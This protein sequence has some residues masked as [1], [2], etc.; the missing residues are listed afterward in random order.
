MIVVQA[1]IHTDSS[2]I[3]VPTGGQNIIGAPK[4]RKKWPLFYNTPHL[5]IALPTFR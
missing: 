2:V 5:G 4:M 3:R 1:V